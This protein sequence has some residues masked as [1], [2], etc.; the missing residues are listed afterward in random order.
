MTTLHA[1]STYNVEPS[2][3]AALASA[4]TAISLPAWL[5]FG[6]ST[7]VYD[8]P[9]ITENLPCFSIV[10]FTDNLSDL[11]QGRNDSAGATTVRDTGMLEVSAWVSRDQ[12]YNNQ[13][14]WTARLRF[15]AAMISKAVN[16][17]A[18]ILI[19]DYA[20]SPT[21]PALT[22]YKVNMNVP[23]FVQTADDPNPAIRRRRALVS[24]W[25]DLRA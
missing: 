15:M 23:E 22:G 24:Y 17:N 13:D 25:W 16:S 20:T 4:L 21:T 8:W 11:Y 14:V 10:H 6:Q 19:R 1:T 2:I 12:R 18:I 7:V 5:T 3:N 9:E